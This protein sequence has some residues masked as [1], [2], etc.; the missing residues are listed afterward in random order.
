MFKKTTAF[1]C[2][3]LILLGNG[4]DS[5]AWAAEIKNS[6]D[7]VS[8]VRVAIPLSEPGSSLLPAE[9]EISNSW[10]LSLTIHQQIP[11]KI[12][13]GRSLSRSEKKRHRARE[14]P[15]SP[16]P[17]TFLGRPEVSNFSPIHQSGQLRTI[18]GSPRID[19]D[20][21]G[22]KSAPSVSEL[23]GVLS[24]GPKFP[25]QSLSPFSFHLPSGQWAS[26]R[27]EG[28]EGFLYSK[29]EL[30][31]QG[32]GNLEQ[33]EDYF[34]YLDSLLSPM[35]LAAPDLKSLEKIH[36]SSLPPQK[37]NA[38]LNDWLVSTVSK[39]QSQL[40]LLDP[41]LWAKEASIYLIFARAYN[42]L[43]SGKNF[44][45]SL[46]ETELSRIR[47]Q[48]KA[49]SLWLMDIFEIGEIHRWGTGGGSAYSIKG[50]HV[51][52]ELGGDEGL[53]NL[54]ERAQK[55]GIKVGVDFIPNHVSLDGDFIK[56][57]PE[58]VMHVV[59]PQNL[60]DEEIMA[61][62]PLHGNGKPAFYLLHSDHY[63]ENGKFVSKKILVQ[64][65]ITDYGGDMW[66]DLA[67][68]DYSR[69]ETR[70]WELDQTAK[71]FGPWSLNFV[72]RDMAYE[73]LNAR[74]FPR[75]LFI[76]EHERDSSRGWMRDALT[77]FIEDFKARWKNLN[78]AEFMAQMAQTA[79][80]ENP[81]AALFDEAY[82]DFSALSRAG[83]NAVYN[84]NTHDG[85]RGQYGLYDAMVSASS[86]GSVDILREALK[87]VCFRMWQKGGAGELDFIGTH[88]GGEGNPVDKFGRYFKAAALTALLFRPLLT[89]NGLEQ[90]VG[91][92][93]NLIGD[94]SKSVDTQ[95]AIPFDIPVLINWKNSN[96]DNQKYLETLWSVGEKYKGALGK[97]LEVLSPKTRTSLVAWSSGY[98]ENGV[99][100]ALIGVSNFGE[101]SGAF[102]NMD[103]P[104][105]EA[106]GA[107]KPRADRDYILRDVLNLQKDGTPT[108]YRRSGAELLKNGLYIGL[109]AGGTQLFEVEEV[110]PPPK[111]GLDFPDRRLGA[112]VP[113]L[114]IVS[115]FPIAGEPP[116]GKPPVASIPGNWDLATQNLVKA[117]WGVFGLLQL[118]QLWQ[119]FVN[120]AQVHPF[121][122][123]ALSLF[124]VSAGHLTAI[125]GIPFMGVLSGILADGILMSYYT[126]QKE[127]A[128]SVVQT[129]GVVMASLVLS[130]VAWAGFVPLAVYF[131]ALPLILTHLAVNALKWAGKLPEKIA[132]VSIWDSWQKFL[133]LAGMFLLPA[134]VSV[135]FAG[136]AGGVSLGLPLILGSVAAFAGLGLMIAESRGKLS[137]KW[138]SR[139]KDI[140]A[141]LATALFMFMPLAQIHSIFV[142][143]AGVG[144]LALPS[145][146]MGALGNLL[147]LPR[148]ILT[149]NKIWFV[150]SGWAVLVGGL[151]VFLSLAV[152]GVLAAWLY[153]GVLSA[154]AVS[155]LYYALKRNQKN[156]KESSL[157]RSLRFLISKK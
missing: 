93:E 70:Q 62:V 151:G 86:G 67:Q 82:T 50:Y 120:L 42:R 90:G 122:K 133:T 22:A 55:M 98:A 46:D 136:A 32:Q 113:R 119:N 149:K 144:G 132:G 2:V 4:F 43:K 36:S 156:S 78:G 69:P 74:Y 13:A 157:W 108:V 65:P 5:S 84:K 37:K 118:P 89:Y 146:F 116:A 127:M 11:D 60:S 139:W 68:M 153:L 75:W 97:A 91:Q 10:G 154:A 101:K 57:F 20:G 64:Y 102:F 115:H 76:L 134:G 24:D 33:L 3:G 59:P 49:D 72:R 61:Q 52:P 104:T 28:L 38:R 15:L 96:P 145:F 71:M 126:G 141:W 121:L 41:S 92:A 148:A 77:R 48:I 135:M 21:N 51:K 45:D 85:S 29:L 53:K 35:G 9:T 31:K 39:Y 66:T 87:N 44:M 95:K 155:F 23:K 150:G 128:S 47:N 1:L 100:K 83:S 124:D 17:T 94:L 137:E 40:E 19:F 14:G 123:S 6:F 114:G 112:I 125:S 107:F 130:Q 27:D 16:L 105:L 81:S 110:L 129:I 131:A 109:D 138:S 30:E 140:G 117:S 34:H 103:S 106:F 25:G 152:H 56:E 80:K 79:R 12:T 58:G 73:I 54:I 143:P 142:N 8:S 147:M 88:D 99:Q 111:S 26:A 7:P 63:P 18:H